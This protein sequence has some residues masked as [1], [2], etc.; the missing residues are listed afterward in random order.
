MAILAD[1]IERVM[2]TFERNDEREF[3]PAALEVVETP[4]PPTGRIVAV[5][6]ILFFVVAVAW[7]FIGRVDINA[8]AQGRILPTGNVKVIQP[9]ETGMV[10]AIHVHD[11][12]AVRQGELLIELDP[13]LPGA[14]RDS[15]SNDLVQAKLDVA[16]LNGLAGA[17]RGGAP[18]FRAPEGAPPE[19]IAEARLAMTAQY[20]EQAAKIAK[21]DQDIAQKDAEAAGIAAEIDKV[22]MDL[23]NLEEKDR[24]NKELTSRGFGTTLAALDAASALSDARHDLEISLRKA[25]ENAASKA[26]LRRERDAAISE[27]QSG[28]MSD[29]RKAEEAQNEVGQNLIKAESRSTAT[30]LRAPTDGVVEQLAVHSL[31]GVVLPGQHLL[32]IVPNT[33]SL[34][35]E[36]KLEN[37]DVGF[38]YPGQTVR[39]KIETFNFTRYGL[40][41]GKV[42][43][44]SRDIVD[45]DPRTGQQDNTPESPDNPAPTTV[46]KADSPTYV[47]RIA[48]SQTSMMVDGVERPL[49]PGMSVTTEIRTGSRSIADYIL[50]PIAKKT[51]ESLHER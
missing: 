42:V 49:K 16:R 9:L 7:A 44:V 41:Q 23:P 47:A 17:F 48:L 8:T 11:G 4:A 5:T 37:K 6:I 20:A 12:Q 21:V 13:T 18:V 1:T 32:T 25:E 19:R 14:D 27:Y 10:R 24:I 35:V 50:S 36:A 28:V 22:K 45:E 26:S 33:G 30:D 39:V 43:D 15:A 3:L 31:H 40:I 51:E 34:M 38:V 2:R 46:P 29:L